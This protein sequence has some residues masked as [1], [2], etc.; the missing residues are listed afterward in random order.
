MSQ[1]SEL[2]LADRMRLL[3]PGLRVLHVIGNI[4]DAVAR[5]EHTSA[6]AERMLKPLLSADLASS[7]SIPAW[8]SCRAP[9]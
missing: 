9:N 5:Q 2:H 3:P 8:G 1:T 7:S 6:G 4:D